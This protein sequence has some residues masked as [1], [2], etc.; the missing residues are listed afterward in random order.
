MPEGCAVSG[1]IP[2]VSYTHLDVYKRQ[3]LD[4]AHLA[5]RCFFEALELTER[6][7]L[8]SHANAREP[9]SYTHLDVYKRQGLLRLLSYRQRSRQEAEEYL[10]RKGFDDKLITTVLA[11]MEPVSYTH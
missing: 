6:P 2:P 9:V 11:E 7:P 3:I 8:V 4:L 1:R 5:P 10:R